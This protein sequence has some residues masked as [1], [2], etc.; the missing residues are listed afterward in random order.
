MN[1]IIRYLIL[2][3]V[4]IPN[5][6][7]FYL[8]FK[9][10]TIYPSFFFLNLLFDPI[11]FGSTILINNVSIEIVNACV[12][13][14]AYYLLLILNL[15]TSKI[16]NRIS[17]ILFSF[18]VF[19]ELNLLRIFILSLFL[20]SESQWFAITHKFSWYFLSTI[21]VIGI[22]FLE[23]KLFKIKEIPFYSDIKYIYKNK[24]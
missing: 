8:V 7:I 4:A 18:L 22:W 3:I 5:L 6:L 23:V 14:S 24:K 16:K 17:A 20:I 19:L 2:I 12:A 10:L 15:S 21:F 9:P 1:L 13:G 11:L